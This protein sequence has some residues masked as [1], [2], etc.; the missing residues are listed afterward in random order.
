MKD[1][2]KKTS[3]KNDQVEENF[4]TEIAKE[5]YSTPLDKKSKTNS[6]KG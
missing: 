2:K 4:N 3:K 5:I 1:K 6:K